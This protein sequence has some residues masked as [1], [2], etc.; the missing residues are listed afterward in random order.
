MCK[1]MSF[2]E[3]IDTVLD[4]KE[5][6]ELRYR[7]KNY[8]G[9]H[10]YGPV[11]SGKDTLKQV[12]QKCSLFRVLRN[13]MYEITTSYD[14]QYGV[15]IQFKNQFRTNPKYDNEFVCIKH[16]VDMVD[17]SDFGVWLNET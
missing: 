1:T 13:R 7:I 12:L 8:K 16:L 4:R 10:F 6:E 11:R 14:K 5:Q 17:V 9:I 2:C 3:Y 15:G